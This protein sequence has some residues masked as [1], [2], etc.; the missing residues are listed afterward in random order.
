M[1]NLAGKK[2]RHMLS[3]R[4]KKV[5]YLHV[6]YASPN[7]FSVMSYYHFTTHHLVLEDSLTAA[8]KQNHLTLEESN[9]Y[10]LFYRPLTLT[11]TLNAQVT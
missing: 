9:E 8:T 6:T 5:I 7:M 2:N 10:T 11:L 1:Y 3:F 4:Q